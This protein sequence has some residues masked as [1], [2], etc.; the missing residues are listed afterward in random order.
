[1]GSV[2]RSPGSLGS[3]AKPQPTSI[4]KHCR[5]WQAE[6]CMNMFEKMWS[7]WRLLLFCVGY[8][9]LTT[10]PLNGWQNTFPTSIMQPLLQGLFWCTRPSWLS[11]FGMGCVF[12]CVKMK[13]REKLIVWLIDSLGEFARV[14]INRCY[15]VCRVSYQSDASGQVVVGVIAL[16]SAMNWAT[17]DATVRRIFKVIATRLQPTSCFAMRLTMHDVAFLNYPQINWRLSM[18]KKN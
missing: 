14:S 5:P 8:F 6:L 11:K 12:Q 2:V 15:D 9:G 16:S 18:R 17:L 13:L 10:H 3:G 1:M 7:F 4:L